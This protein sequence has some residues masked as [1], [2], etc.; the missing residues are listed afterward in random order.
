MLTQATAATLFGKNKAD[1][2]DVLVE[3]DES[4]EPVSRKNPPSV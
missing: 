1:T 2:L 3:P 4:D